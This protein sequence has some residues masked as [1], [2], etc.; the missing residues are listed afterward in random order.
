MEKNLIKGYIYKITNLKN[1][2]CYIGKTT[3]NNINRRFKQHIHYALNLK[4]GS[5]T[6]LHQAIR[7]YGQDNFIIELLDIV[8]GPDLLEEIEK[9]YIQKYHTWIK[10]PLCQGYNQ[11][12][13]GEGT[14]Y[15]SNDFNEI[16]LE[17]IISLYEQVK[18][19]NEVA[20]RLQIHKTTVHRYLAM[21]N[22]QIDSSKIVAIRETGKKV[23]IYKNN[24]IIAIYPS[25]GD[26]A[27]HFE[28]KE[29]PSHISEVC[30]G[31]RKNVKGYTAKFTND[32]IFN[33][34][35]I[36]PTLNTVR[37]TNK[38]KRISMIDIQTEQEL[39]IFESGCEAGRYFQLNK[40]AS[41]TTCIKRAIQRNGTWRGY[42]WKYI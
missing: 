38:K 1:N 25:L 4:G 27:K 36:L 23:A 37:Q 18:N 11:T 29:Y 19:V 26:A 33:E 2:F 9:F 13:G 32:E 15:T 35:F 8:C 6:S 34:N 12:K 17:K 21:N 39:K 3:H 24:E 42:K 5:E 14:N 28:E 16:L 22:V 20:R 40:P 30:Y 10:D 31:K 41:A 7:D